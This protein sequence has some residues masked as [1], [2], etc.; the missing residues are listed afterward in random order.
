MHQTLSSKKERSNKWL[1][2]SG[3]SHNA[4]CKVVLQDSLLQGMRKLT[5]F[6]HIGLL[7]VFNYLLHTKMLSEKTPF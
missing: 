7:E 1:T 4:L 2:S 6:D 5:G 3:V